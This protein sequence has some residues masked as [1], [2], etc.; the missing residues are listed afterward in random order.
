MLECANNI[1]SICDAD[2]I[3]KGF[4]VF[5]VVVHMMVS[6]FF[7]FWGGGLVGFMSFTSVSTWTRFSHPE[8]GSRTF[9][10]DG[11]TYLQYTVWKPPKMIIDWTFLET[12]TK[13]IDKGYWY[14][15]P[16]CDRKSA[17]LQFSHAYYQ[18]KCDLTYTICAPRI[19]RQLYK[20]DSYSVG[21]LK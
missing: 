2:N 12:E 8:D 15:T 10:W 19:T 18:I 5:M 14:W 6:P 9:L 1:F 4:Q 21:V 11:R 3:F 16:S 20:L 17:E 7:F 13:N